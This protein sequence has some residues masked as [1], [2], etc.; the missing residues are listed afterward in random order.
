MWTD[1]DDH[2]ITDTGLDWVKVDQVGLAA[3]THGARD[4]TT[5]GLAV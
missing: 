3:Q 1:E 2:I 5:A 4:S